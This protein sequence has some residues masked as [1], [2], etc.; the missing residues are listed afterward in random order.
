MGQISVDIDT[1]HKPASEPE[2][3]GDRIVVDLVL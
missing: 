3:A 2:L 1:G